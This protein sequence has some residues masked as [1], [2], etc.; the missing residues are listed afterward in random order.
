[1]LR[2]GGGFDSRLTIGLFCRSVVNDWK[3]I[4]V[5]YDKCTGGLLTLISLMRSQNSCFNDST[6]KYYCVN[7]VGLN[8][9]WFD[10]KKYLDTESIPYFFSM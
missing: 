10:I 5:K 2:I 8:V 7:I 4:C 9:S 1:M 6:D 3:N